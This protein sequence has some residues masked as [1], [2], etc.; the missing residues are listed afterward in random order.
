MKKGESKKGK[1]S[2]RELRKL[3]TP[4]QSYLLGKTQVRVERVNCRDCERV[5]LATA[6][7]K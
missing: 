5:I 6:T 1:E 3:K 4:Q 7:I 2:R